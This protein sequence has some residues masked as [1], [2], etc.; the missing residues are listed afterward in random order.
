MV[1]TD[2]LAREGRG[3]VGR[4][5][6][7]T[8]PVS[9]LGK[10]GWVDSAIMFKTAQ[11][12]GPILTKRGGVGMNHTNKGGGNMGLNHSVVLKWG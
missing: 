3:R 10:R 12:A 4:Y 7:G 11:G 1:G 8:R 9:T 6:C 2:P 5:H